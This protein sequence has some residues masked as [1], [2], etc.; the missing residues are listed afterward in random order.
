MGMPMDGAP[1]P[2]P[3]CGPPVC[4]PAPCGPAPCGQ[5]C[6][7]SW[8]LG[9]RLIYLNNEAK[10]KFDDT[11]QDID[12]IRDLNFSPSYLTGEV[13]G[14][15]RFAPCFALTYTFRIPRQDGGWG[16]LPSNFR[17]D[18]VTIPQGSTTNW[19]YTPYLIKQEAEY[20]ITA[21]CNLRIGAVLGGEVLISDIKVDYIDP[22]GLSNSLKNTRVWGIP[23]VG[24]IAEFSPIN[25]VFLRFKGLYQFVPTRAGG[26]TLDGD[27]RIFPEFGGGSYGGPS[28]FKLYV[29]AGYRY[30]N[31]QF[32]EHDNAD[33]LLVQ[34]GP[35]GEVGVIF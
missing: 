22:Q 26:F 28:M 25:Q 24:G 14:A 32:A 35:Y 33:Y 29:G 20:Y 1:C 15:I 30:Q 8:E 6:N 27:V 7:N 2:P 19:K 17:F 13:Y 23:S 4:G 18:G 3:T 5:L 31:V 9:G 16:V 21:G 10:I 12:F 11:R 34:H